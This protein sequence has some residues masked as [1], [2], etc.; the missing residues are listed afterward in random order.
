M[1]LA[2]Q[3]DLWDLAAAV[4]AILIAVGVFYSYW[5]AGLVIIGVGYLTLY[6]LR[7]KRL[8]AQS[9]DGTGRE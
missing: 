5:P 6:Y 7:E 4:A 9:R 3:V 2:L 8:A 1:R